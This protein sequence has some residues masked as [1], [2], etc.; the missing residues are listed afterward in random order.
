LIAIAAASCQALPPP[1][2]TDA[3]EGV[4][5]A[6]S[7]EEARDVASSLDALVPEVISALPD[8][9]HRRL[10]VWMQKEPALYRFPPSSTYR[11]ADGFFSDRLARIH[12]RSGADDV[13]RT[14]AHELVHASLGSSWHD[15]P[16]TIEEGLCDVV[17]IRLCPSG[18]VRLRA[19]RLLAAA[20]ALGGFE[21]E[22]PREPG[23][24]GRPDGSDAHCFQQVFSPERRETPLDP[25]EVF[26]SRAGRST[27]A[28]T[29]DTKKALYGLA[30]LVAE[31]IVERRG[32]EGL[33][34]LVARSSARPG[35]EESVDAFLSAAE[36]S[37]E[38][39]A[40]R[41]AISLAI[42][43]AEMIEISRMLPG[44]VLPGEVPFRAAEVGR[45]SPVASRLDAGRGAP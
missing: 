43:P 6:D 7:A 29:S 30:F 3:R 10:E 31:R 25:L 11:E 44:I 4:V 39:E 19:G 12:L 38:P 40:W 2:C 23:D 37:R 13:R 32:V 16:G 45:A 20:L 17:A 14:L 8:A 5:R 22:T 27:S 9:R 33:H 15:L 34:E 42:G 41:R 28:M 18:A 35:T 26:R 24:H 36:L 1:V 21:L